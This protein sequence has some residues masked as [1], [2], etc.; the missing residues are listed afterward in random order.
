M[1]SQGNLGAF[2]AS[3][4]WVSLG[5]WGPYGAVRTTMDE[6]RTILSLSEPQFVL[7]ISVYGSQFSGEKIGLEICLLVLIILSKS[8]SLFFSET[9]SLLSKPKR[10]LNTI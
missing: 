2:S 3:H 1:T 5:A 6:H 4:S 9:L 7:Q 10:K 8:Q